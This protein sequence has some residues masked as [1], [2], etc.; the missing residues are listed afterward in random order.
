V[1]HDEADDQYM[2]R[3]DFNRGIRALQSHGLVY[4]ILIFDRHLPPT[5]TFVDSHPAQRFVLDHVAKPKIRDGE[6]S[7]WRENLCEL[8]A[9]PNIYCKVSGMVTEADWAAWTEDGL[10]RYFD[11]VLDVF[12]PRRLMF[13]SD[14]PVCLVACPYQRWFGIVS[15]WIENLSRDEQARILGGTAVEAYGLELPA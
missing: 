4:D 1:L 3:E 12:G 2:L 15:R 10:K 6:M 9:R 7:P 8:A 5:L 14:W 13:G 11:V